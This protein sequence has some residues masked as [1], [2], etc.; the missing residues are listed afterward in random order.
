MSNDYF[1]DSHLDPFKAQQLLRSLKIKPNKKLGQNFLIDKKIAAKL[2][3]VA[4]LSKDRDKV[5]EVGPGLGSLTS[6]LVENAK[7]IHAVELDKRLYRFLKDKASKHDNLNLILGDVLKITI[8]PHNKVVSTIPYTIT[9]PLLS[10]LLF[11]RDAPEIYMIIEKA[12]ADRIMAQP[13]TEAFSRLSVSVKTFAKPTIIQRVQKNCFYPSPR[14]DLAMIKLIP[15]D[16]IDE[17]F[18]FE[19]HITLFL[20]LLRGIFPYKNKDSVNALYLYLKK[21]GV[22]KADLIGILESNQ[23]SKKIRA[24]ELNDFIMIAKEIESQGLLREN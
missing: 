21:F 2:I 20:N 17:F 8:P 6:L 19:E 12:I 3:S 4:N 9:G 23:K 16:K 14:I 11:K 15:H 10:K 1:F 24:F 7:K 13:N 5:L 22:S 18:N